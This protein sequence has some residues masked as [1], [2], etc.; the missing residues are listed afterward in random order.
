MIPAKA[1]QKGALL[2]AT[3]DYAVPIIDQYVVNKFFINLFFL[4]IFVLIISDAYKEVKKEKPPFLLNN[5]SDKEVVLPEIPE[6][7][8]CIICQ[9]LLQDAVL[10]PCC[11]NSYCDECNHLFRNNFL[12]FLNF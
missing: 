4:I 12:N 10:I 1:D 7:L 9:D 8:K 2:T 5:D 11:G 3:G 6:D